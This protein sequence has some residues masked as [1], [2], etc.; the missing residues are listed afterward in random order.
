M[1]MDRAGGAGN[2]A[3]PRA[4]FV[5]R[6]TVRADGSFVARELA[7]PRGARSQ[8]VFRGRNAPYIDL[9]HKA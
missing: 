1:G 4:R 8:L 2:I 9:I 6:D 3:P 7:S 5:D